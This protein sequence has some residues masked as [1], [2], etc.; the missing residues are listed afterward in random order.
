MA[1]LALSACTSYSSFLDQSIHERVAII[2][3]LGKVPSGAAA[4]VEECTNYAQ[5]HLRLYPE[6]Q[7]KDI[8]ESLCDA[9]WSLKEYA[10]EVY[11]REAILNAE[12]SVHV[13]NCLR[14]MH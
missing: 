5:F 6:F 9:L 13:S 8:A 2:N 12:E 11:P 4:G 14:P 7:K 1:L 10:M 3:C